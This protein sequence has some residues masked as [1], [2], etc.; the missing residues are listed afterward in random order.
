[1][2][3]EDLKRLHEAARSRVK[4]EMA[5]AAARSKAVRDIRENRQRLTSLVRDAGDAL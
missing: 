4:Q 3:E 2:S 5:D 1:M